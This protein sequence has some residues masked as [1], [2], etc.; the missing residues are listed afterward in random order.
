MLVNAP[1]TDGAEPA[2][3]SGGFAELMA[4]GKLDD[5]A[6]RKSAGSRMY[7]MP[8]GASRQDLFF[9]ADSVAG[10]LD[11]LRGRFK[12]SVINGPALRECG[13]LTRHV[14]K[15]LL[16]V[17]AQAASPRAL[18]QAMKHS[19][20]AAGESHGAILVGARSGLPAW[21]GGE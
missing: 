13:A 1:L 10:A 20:D 7:S 14:D 12:L 5:K 4:C 16:V 18:R 11:V 21:L 17:D 9:Q 8:V 6:L 3:R 2:T 15:A 19:G